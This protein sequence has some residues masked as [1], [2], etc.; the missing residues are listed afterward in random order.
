M[1]KLPEFL[2]VFLKILHISFSNPSVVCLYVGYFVIEMWF[3]VYLMSLADLF[4]K[5]VRGQA[6]GYTIFILRLVAG[7]LP[8]VIVPFLKVYLSYFAVLV[9]LVP[10]FHL[11]SATLF[12][13][14]FFVVKVPDETAETID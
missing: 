3:G 11:I 14:T 2:G 9:L 12:L 7:I 8:G 1:I 13:A 6:I 5:S 4:D 10:E